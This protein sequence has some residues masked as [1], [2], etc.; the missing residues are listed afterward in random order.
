MSRLRKTWVWWTAALALTLASQP[1][2]ANG[3]LAD[4]AW[5]KRLRAA[6]F[7]DR[8]IVTSDN[9][10][11]LHMPEQAEDPTVVPVTIYAMLPQTDERYI[12]KVTLLIDLNPVPLAG[13]FKFTPKSGRADISLRVRINDVTPVRAIAE[14]ND[15]TLHMSRTM[16][17]ASGGCSAPVGEDLAVALKRAG[18]MKL[19]IGPNQPDDAPVSSKLRIRHPNITGMQT[20]GGQFT[21]AHYVR[22]VNIRMNDEIIF[23]AETDISVS[24]DP[25]FGFYIAGSES[26]TMVAEVTD[27]SGAT[28]TKEVAV[29][30][31][32]QQ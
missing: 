29:R 15:G 3:D 31:A 2:V 28:F 13:V 24:A 27:S 32:P 18:K 4:H 25:F 6:H 16:V 20:V 10:I 26:G 12:K 8:P 9:V 23:S 17:Y 30:G 5:N 21:P 11:Q 1:S 14:L 7:A 22:T 19:S